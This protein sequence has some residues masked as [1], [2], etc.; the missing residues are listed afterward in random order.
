MFHSILLLPESLDFPNGVFYEDVGKRMGKP[1]LF[2][3]TVN[4]KVTDRSYKYS[5]LYRLFEGFSEML[6]HNNRHPSE[7]ND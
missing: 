1:I 2:H 6:G 3:N 5:F 7:S 4:R